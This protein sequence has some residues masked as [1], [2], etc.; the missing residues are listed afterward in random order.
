MALY[1]THTKLNLLLALPVLFGVSIYLLQTEPKLMLTF[2]LT[3]I[4]GTLFMNPDLDLAHKVKLFSLRGILSFPFRIY[5]RIFR[6]RGISHSI[7]LG[8]STR[9]LYLAA[10]ITLVI[11]FINKS[12][13]M[14]DFMIL[15]KNHKDHFFYGFIGLFLADAFHILIDVLT[16][17]RD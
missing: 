3:F 6:H 15:Y 8:T 11:Y 10:F 14:D 2:G 1:Q 4:Y 16:P 5:S 9:V 17:R 7:L 12:F 13:Y